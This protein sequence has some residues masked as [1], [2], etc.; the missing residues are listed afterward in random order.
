[1]E[2]NCLASNS[3]KLLKH[4]IESREHRSNRLGSQVTVNIW[5]EKKKQKTLYSVQKLS[6]KQIIG[7]I[8]QEM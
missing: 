8:F 7:H 4:P 1:M 2:N 6:L 5:G 3:N